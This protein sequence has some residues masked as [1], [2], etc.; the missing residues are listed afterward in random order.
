MARVAHVDR[1]GR[2]LMAPTRNGPGVTSPGR[3]DLDATKHQDRGPAYN[4]CS[5]REHAT[6]ARATRRRTVLAELVDAWLDVVG[7]PA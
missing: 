1:L 2:R 5:Y 3:A 4:A 6:W 7:R